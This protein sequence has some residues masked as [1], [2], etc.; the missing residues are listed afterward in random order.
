VWGDRFGP[1]GAAYAASLWSAHREEL[2]AGYL[3]RLQR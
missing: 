1:P 3:E 2:L